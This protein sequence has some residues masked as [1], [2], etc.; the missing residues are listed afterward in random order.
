MQCA[1]LSMA[2]DQMSITF[3]LSELL[4]PHVMIGSMVFVASSCLQW[5]IGQRLANMRKDAQGKVVTKRHEAPSGGMFEYVSCP[6]YFAEIMIY[7]GLTLILWNFNFTWLS[8]V[9]F[10]VVNQACLAVLTHRWYF[11]NF[12]DYPRYRKALIPFIF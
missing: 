11:E 4:R 3:D 12:K 7:T 9:I 6:H 5:N 1:I 10:T 2:F 8:S